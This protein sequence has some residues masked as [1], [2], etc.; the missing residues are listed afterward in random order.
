MNPMSAQSPI[1]AVLLAAGSGTRFGGGKLVHPLEDGI[2]IAAHAARNLIAA[3]LD[4]VAVVRAGD[5]PLADLLEQEG[6]YVTPC[7][8]A[9]HG[10]GHTLA[11]GISHARES[12][13]WIVALAD[14]PLVKPATIQSIAAALMSGAKIAA[15]VYRG[16]RGHPVGF[17]ASLR[18]EL[19]AL[20]GD[21][22]ARPVLQRHGDDIRLLEC[23]DAGVLL[24]IDTKTDLGR[25]L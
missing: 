13:G 2:A 24:D 22:G 25:A 23:D 1:T 4:V 21:V 17:A 8:E 19:L 3:G 12:A 15:P 7:A 20:S 10:M 18:P 16:E 6:C 14:M 11:H 5:F 9:V